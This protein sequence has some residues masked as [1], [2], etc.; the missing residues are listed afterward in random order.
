MNDPIKIGRERTRQGQ[1]VGMPGFGDAEPPEPSV[2][3]IFME[4]FD[5]QWDERL[6]EAADDLSFGQE[7]FSFYPLLHVL[8]DEVMD[9]SGEEDTVDVFDLADALVK[10]KDMTEWRESYQKWKAEVAKEV[11][12]NRKDEIADAEWKH[13]AVQSENADAEDSM[14]DYY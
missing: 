8:R 11:L 2:H 4:N 6:D 14:F 13:L 10:G 5:E 12:E 9:R 7:P 1:E 3:E